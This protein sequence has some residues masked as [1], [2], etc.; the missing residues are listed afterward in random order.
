MGCFLG[1]AP[2][3]P[4]QLDLPTG[5]DC[6]LFWAEWKLSRLGRAVPAQ[7]LKWHQEAL[8]RERAKAN[9]RHKRML[10]LMD[11]F[12]EGVSESA[13]AWKACAPLP[14]LVLKE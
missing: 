5:W 10:R 6:R 13:V 1:A 9:E 2:Q 3:C 8:Q 12:E 14:R 7:A 11:C 4:P